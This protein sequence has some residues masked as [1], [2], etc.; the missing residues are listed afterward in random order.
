[1]EG[2]LI[3][4]MLDMLNFTAI[5]AQPLPRIYLY[6]PIPPTENLV[7]H[8]TNYPSKKHPYPSLRYK[9]NSFAFCITFS[10]THQQ[11]MVV[12]QINELHASIQIT[13]HIHRERTQTNKQKNS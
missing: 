6:P 5:Q 8:Q 9:A 7:R 12:N 4:H 13:L 11:I 1:M 3:I 10:Q 2:L